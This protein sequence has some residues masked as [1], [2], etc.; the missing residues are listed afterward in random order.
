MSFFEIIILIVIGYYTWAGL[1]SGFIRT[2]GGFI[3]LLVGVFFASR[4]FEIIAQSWQWLFFNNELLAKVSIFIFLFVVIEKFFKLAAYVLDRAFNL[5]RFIPFT[6]L[7]NRIAGGV[8]GFI[9][10]SLI[11]GLFIYALVRLPF[12]Q[13]LL[14]AVDNSLLA[15][16]LLKFAD[17][18]TPLIYDTFEKMKVLIQM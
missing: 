2:L 4:Y 9:E 10:G 1:K 3:G 15:R 6:K 7:I 11:I 14:A 17:I 8:F 13:S 18:L 12:S 5:L 16:Q